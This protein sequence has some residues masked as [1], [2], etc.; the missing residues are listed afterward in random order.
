MLFV[1]S[2]KSDHFPTAGDQYRAA[3]IWLMSGSS[4]TGSNIQ[5]FY[6][7]PKKLQF[8]FVEEE[9]KAV[10]ALLSL[11]CAQRHSHTSLIFNIYFPLAVDIF[12]FT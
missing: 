5:D 7:V 10:F 1:I 9:K 8:L 2:S 11:L 3:I 12:V 6:S 4:L